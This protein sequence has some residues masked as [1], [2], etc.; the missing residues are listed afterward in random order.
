M[1]PG[2]HDPDDKIKTPANELKK[3]DR[4]FRAIRIGP[5]TLV[6]KVYWRIVHF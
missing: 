5:V 6:V 3:D 1:K 2:C 4:P